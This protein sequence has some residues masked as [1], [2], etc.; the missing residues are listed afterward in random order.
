MSKKLLSKN[1]LLT[2]ELAT[3]EMDKQLNILRRSE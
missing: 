2:M 3:A 1:K